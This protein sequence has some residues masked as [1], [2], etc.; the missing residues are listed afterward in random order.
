[1]TDKEMLF[2]ASSREF[3]SILSRDPRLRELEREKYNPSNEYHLILELLHGI[4]WIKKIPVMPITPAVW[5]LLWVMR[6]G[7]VTDGEIITELDSDVFFYLLAK[8]IKRTGADPVEITR[9]AAGF[10]RKNGLTPKEI[11]SELTA[12]VRLAFAPLRMLPAT[13]GTGE[14]AFDSDWLASIVSVVART[15]NERSVYVLYEMPLSVCC[16]YYVQARKRYDYNGSIRKRNSGEVDKEI[17]EHTMRL[18]EEFLKSAASREQSPAADK[19]DSSAPVSAPNR[20]AAS[21]P[22]NPQTGNANAGTH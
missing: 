5:G 10:S 4:H 8:G 19:S 2:L 14:L 21:A 15:A 3:K 13:P 6:N 7:Y 16:M 11:H 12:L 1:M 22:E 9:N 18:G 17:F 20:N